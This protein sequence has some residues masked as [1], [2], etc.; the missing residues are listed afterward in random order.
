MTVLVFGGVIV[1]MRRD[2]LSLKFSLLCQKAIHGLAENKLLKKDS[3]YLLIKSFHA[4]NKQG[5]IKLHYLSSTSKV[6]WQ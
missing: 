5:T 4:I 6:T 2:A 3:K 1:K